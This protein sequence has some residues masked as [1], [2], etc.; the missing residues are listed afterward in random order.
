MNELKPGDLVF[1]GRPAHHVGI[2]IGNNKVIHA[3]HTGSVVQIVDLRTYHYFDNA[4]RVLPEPG[5]AASAPASA[6]PSSAN[7]PAPRPAAPAT[8]GAAAYTVRAHD[9]LYRIAQRVLGDGNRWRE[10]FA[11]N[12]GTIADP[13]RL[14]PGMALRLPG[15]AA[16]S[17]APVSSPASTPLVAAPATPVAPSAAPATP[18]APL[19]PAAPIA[20]AALAAPAAPVAPPPP[21]TPAVPVAFAMPA[22]PAVPLAPA[23]PSYEEAIAQI[24][25]MRQRLTAIQGEVQDLLGKLQAFGA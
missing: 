23:G 3:P 11:L 20:P 17:P 4:R 22:A 14:Y 8:P 19:A 5:Q 25:A 21:P 24:E 18:A 15:A 12:R 9:S 13:N 7:K 2:Y 16:S 1:A 10:I 6:A